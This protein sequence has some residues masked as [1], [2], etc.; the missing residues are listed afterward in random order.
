MYDNPLFP[1]SQ[2]C[3]PRLNPIAAQGTPKRLRHLHLL[4]S[5]RWL[6]HQ[7]SRGRLRPHHLLRPGRLIDRRD[8]PRRRSHYRR[9]RLC[10]PPLPSTRRPSASRAAVSSLARPSGLH[11]GDP[12]LEPEFRQLRPRARHRSPNGSH[13]RSRGDPGGMYLS[14]LF[15]LPFSLSGQSSGRCKIPSR[16]H[17]D[18][19]HPLGLSRVARHSTLKQN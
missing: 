15:P 9:L 11:H 8:G 5:L 12:E 4:L 6:W 7:A 1:T 17:K 18:F 3:N 16:E 13:I 19:W 14:P 2:S 10:K